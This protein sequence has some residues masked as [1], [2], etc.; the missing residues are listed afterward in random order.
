MNH[1][2]CLLPALMTLGTLVLA[3]EEPPQRR[4]LVLT[5]ETTLVGQ[6]E[7]KD[8]HLEIKTASGSSLIPQARVLKLCDTPE[9]AYVFLKQRSK[10]KDP[11]DGLRLAR[12]C[13]KHE[14][15]EQARL[16]AEEVLAHQPK[17][18]EAQ[19][20]IR[21]VTDAGT[22]LAPGAPSQSKP[23]VTLATAGEH[24]YSPET[25]RSFTQRLQPVLINSCGTGA[26]HGGGK[27]TGFELQRP[28]SISLV[29]P[30]LTR[31]NLVQTLRLIDKDDSP[32]SALLRK[33][34][35]AHGG[36][37][38]PP[39][40]GKDAP[41]YQ[42]LE[43]WVMTVAPANAGQPLSGEI[44]VDSRK[45]EPAKAPAEINSKPRLP[46]ALEEKF[47]SLPIVTP[48]PAKLPQDTYLQGA[49]IKAPAVPTPKTPPQD[50]FDPVQFNDQYHPG[51]R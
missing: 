20:I 26:C 3:A 6:I 16:E 46:A 35:E 15:A 39:L 38:R 42:T 4:V 28:P 19:R 21:A 9:D 34:L 49:A 51:K 23:P 7:L 11:Q 14:L 45:V 17:N 22:Q 33:A 27:G 10:G 12:W 5:N 8:G 32:N 44:V 1:S 43:A 18:L 13:L 41:A 29:Q 36:A 47:A 30:N 50:P 48:E 37:T 31:H 40:T 25:L 24:S 2:L